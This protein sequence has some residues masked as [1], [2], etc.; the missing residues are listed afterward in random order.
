MLASS[1]DVAVMVT[2]PAVDGAVHAPVLGLMAPPLADQVTPFV[3]PPVAVVLNVVE[4]LTVRVGAPGLSGFT[5][6]VCGVTVTEA[7]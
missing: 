3:T 5:T 1:L 2:F 7:S 4:L 6:T